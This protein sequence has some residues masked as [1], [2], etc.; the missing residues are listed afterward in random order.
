M[1]MYQRDILQQVQMQKMGFGM[2]GEKV[3][4]PESPDRPILEPLLSPGDVVTP[5]ELEGEG[6]LDA[7]RVEGGDAR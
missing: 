2:F 4:L 3:V 7:R 6:Y 5:L 1:W